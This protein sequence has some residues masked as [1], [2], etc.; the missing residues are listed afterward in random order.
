MT[1]KIE[2]TFARSFSENEMNDNFQRM[3]TLINKSNLNVAN[4]KEL[5]HLMQ[6]IS[7]VTFRNFVK[8]FAQE[9]TLEEA[10]DDYMI[11]MNLLKN[12]L[13]KK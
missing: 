5:F 9:V 11:E 6:I 8:I 3:S 10:M 7:S 4:D 13:F 1:F 12:G 2:R